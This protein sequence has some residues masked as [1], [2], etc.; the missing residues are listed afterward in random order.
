MDMYKVYVSLTKPD[1]MVICLQEYLGEFREK[2]E[3]VEQKLRD[4]D[5]KASAELGVERVNV[6]LEH[7]GQHVYYFRLTMME[8]KIVGG[9]KIFTIMEANKSG[10]N[11]GLSSSMTA[12]LS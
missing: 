6:M 10:I 7:S 2:L 4:Q 12:M 11:S 3:S 9:N 5:G 8:E 1:P